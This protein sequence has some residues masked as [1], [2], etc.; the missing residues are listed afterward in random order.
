MIKKMMVNIN[1]IQGGERQPGKIF[2]RAEIT[3]QL[4]NLGV[5][6]RVGVGENQGVIQ[7]EKIGKNHDKEKKI[8][9]SPA[10]KWRGRK[11]GLI[12]FKHTLIIT[13]S[14]GFMNHD[15]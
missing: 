14:R 13:K 9:N 5:V 2:D 11:L 8:K 12:G 7:P 3:G 10:M 1:I 15:L 4:S 6:E